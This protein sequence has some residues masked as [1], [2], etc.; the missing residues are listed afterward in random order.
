MY[1]IQKLTESKGQYSVTLPKS[2]VKSMGLDKYKVVVL[3]GTEE[4]I[5]HVEGYDAE[6]FNKDRAKTG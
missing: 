4:H 2:L 1:Y 3:W 5:I 6:R